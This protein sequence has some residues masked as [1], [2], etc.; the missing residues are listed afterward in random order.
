MAS[1]S[2]RTPT[3]LLQN[4]S[5]VAAECSCRCGST[6][7]A[8]RWNSTQAEKVVEG[9]ETAAAGTEAVTPIAQCKFGMIVVKK[10][11]PTA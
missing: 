10:Y 2:M 6:L 9:G 4:F 5:S 8:R 7:P 3:R 11:N 1:T